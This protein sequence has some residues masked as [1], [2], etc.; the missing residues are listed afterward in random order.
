MNLVGEWN[1]QVEVVSLFWFSTFRAAAL[2]HGTATFF[3]DE[4]RFS[5]IAWTA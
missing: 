2:P 1:L 3:S 5:V 4:G